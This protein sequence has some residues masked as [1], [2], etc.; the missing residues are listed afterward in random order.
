M[1][2]GLQPAKEIPEALRYLL[3]SKSEGELEC[4]TW[5]DEQAFTAHY[6]RD[7]EFLECREFRL[8]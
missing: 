1:I 6:Y 5:H 3:N 8:A 7:G 2:E 4:I